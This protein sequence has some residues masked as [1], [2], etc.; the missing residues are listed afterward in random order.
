MVQPCVT[1]FGLLNTVT[2]VPG[3]NDNSRHEAGVHVSDFF[4]AST[5]LDNSTKGTKLKALCQ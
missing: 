4:A 5:W 1:L 2:V 3:K